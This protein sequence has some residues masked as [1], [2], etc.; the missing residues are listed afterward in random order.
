MRLSAVTIRTLHAKRIAL[1]VR[2]ASDVD[3]RFPC[4]VVTPMAHSDDT[5]RLELDWEFRLPERVRV[6]PIADVLPDGLTLELRRL[7]QRDG[8]TPYDL[9]TVA[10]YVGDAGEHMVAMAFR[11]VYDH[12]SDRPIQHTLEIYATEDYEHLDAMGLDPRCS[13]PS[14]PYNSLATPPP[15]TSPRTLVIASPSSLG[16]VVGKHVAELV[17]SQL[18]CRHHAVLAMERDRELERERP[19][20]GR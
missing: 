5:T 6:P 19:D 7:Q 20:L 9:S 4:D 2:R 14:D 11:P 17:A 10:G 16:Q 13:M 1:Q 8:F 15:G 18:I 3:C 12:T